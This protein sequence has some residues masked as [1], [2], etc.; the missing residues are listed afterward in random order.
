MQ[1]L[2][3]FSRNDTLDETLA[4]L[5]FREG[6][7][8]ME[9]EQFPAL[10]PPV[11]FLARQMTIGR[12]ILSSLSLFI[13]IDSNHNWIFLRIRVNDIEPSR[14][15]SLRRIH[16]TTAQVIESL[17]LTMWYCKNM[18]KFQR[19]IVDVKFYWHWNKIQLRVIFIFNLQ[20]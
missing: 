8:Q 17:E 16:I 20:I 9:R 15:F 10:F 12:W 13:A 3:S 14:M 6:D 1:F 4:R 11:P 2:S 5:N 18:Q 19:K 7:F